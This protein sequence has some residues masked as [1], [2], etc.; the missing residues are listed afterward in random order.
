[1]RMNDGDRGAKQEPPGDRARRVDH[2]QT[3]PITCW[4]KAVRVRDGSEMVETL[5]RVAWFIFEFGRSWSDLYRP[6]GSLW[7]IST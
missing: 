7:K 6:A 4:R 1:M 5:L 2:A 3:G